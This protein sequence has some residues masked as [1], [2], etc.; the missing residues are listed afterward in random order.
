[1]KERGNVSR[2]VQC[3]RC[4]R[5]LCVDPARVSVAQTNLPAGPRNQLSSNLLHFGPPADG[6]TIKTASLSAAA[7]DESLQSDS[8]SVGGLM[9]RLREGGNI[10]VLQR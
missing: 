6:S 2:R 1:M 8:G 10:F 9:R 5:V 4:V 7:P 3:L